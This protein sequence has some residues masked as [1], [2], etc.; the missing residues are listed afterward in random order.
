MKGTVKCGRGVQLRG[1]S[2]VVGEF[3][4]GDSQ[5]WYGS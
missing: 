3:S 2:N 4:E 5:M 1:Q